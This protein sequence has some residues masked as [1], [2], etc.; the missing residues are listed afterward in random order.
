MK[1]PTSK[2]DNY[3]TGSIHQNKYILCTGKIFMRSGNRS[4]LHGSVKSL[5]FSSLVY[6]NH[7]IVGWDGAAKNPL[8]KIKQ[9][10]QKTSLR[11][12]PL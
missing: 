10:G 12:W 1:V 8:G 5:L 2:V 9:F 6:S 7:D 4:H 3:G 11:K